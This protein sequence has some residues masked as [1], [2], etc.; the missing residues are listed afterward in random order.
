MV[1]VNCGGALPA[2]TS[3][4]LAWVETLATGLVPRAVMLRVS[5]ATSGLARLRLTVLPL[6]VAVTTGS[7]MAVPPEGVKLTV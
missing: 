1:L 3:M 7:A 4:A 2:S 5:P 6:A